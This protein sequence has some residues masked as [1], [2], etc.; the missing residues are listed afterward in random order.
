MSDKTTILRAFNEH[1]FEFLDDIL[2]IFPEN[3]DIITAKKTFELTKKANPTIIIKVWFNY[4]Y[5]PYSEIIQNGDISFFFNKNYEE[6]LGSL[7]NS[8]E[9]LSVID[10]LREPVQLMSDEN[11]QHSIKYI[12]N[13]SKL[14]SIYDKLIS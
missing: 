2:K 13:L 8:K 11:K 9:I 10:T 1:F 5:T 6:D 7:S 12:Q 14:S 4:I 3:T